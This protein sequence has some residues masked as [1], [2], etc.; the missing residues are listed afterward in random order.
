MYYYKQTEEKLQVLLADLIID[1]QNGKSHNIAYNEAQI[2][3]YSAANASFNPDTDMIG[4]FC[5]WNVPP[6]DS[7]EF[8]IARK[9]LNEAMK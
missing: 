8:T 7:A 4:D 9:L 1:V 5:Y 6:V 2:I 3:I